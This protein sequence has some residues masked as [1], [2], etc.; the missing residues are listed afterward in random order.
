[1]SIEERVNRIEDAIGIMKNLLVSHDERLEG[2]FRALERS[3]EEFEFKMG[4]LV[5]S[6]IRTEA[7]IAELKQSSLELKQVSISLKDASQSQLSR[8][9]AIESRL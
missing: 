2:Y 4:A 7:E 6:Q 9:E 3:R 5:D 8:I 1:M